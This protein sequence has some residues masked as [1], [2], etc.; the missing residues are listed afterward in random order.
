MDP[1]TNPP[2]W[3]NWEEEFIST[4]DKKEKK[5]AYIY[6][7]KDLQV[8][9]KEFE[10]ASVY[11]SKPFNIDGNVAEISLE[12]DEYNP[13]KN[14]LNRAVNHFDTSVE[15]YICFKDVVTS[16]DDWIPILPKQKQII[17]N[18]FLL[19]EDSQT[20]KLRFKY[21]K[22]KETTVYKNGVKL[23]KQFWS[24]APDNTIKIDKN[25]DKYSIYTVRYSPDINTF[26]PWDIELNEEDRVVVPFVDVNGNREEIFYEGANRNGEIVLSKHPYV[27]Y[28]K[29]NADDLTYRPIKI[30]LQSKDA[31][32]KIAAPNNTTLDIVGP[33][34]IGASQVITKNITDYKYLTESALT[35]YNTTMVNGQPVNAQFEYYQDGRKLCFTE[36]FNNSNIISNQT[37]NHG[38]AVVRVK[39]DYLKVKVRFKIIVRN[40]SNKSNTITPSVRGYSL[41]FKVAR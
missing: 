22:D 33:D 14:S 30:T 39:Y 3:L 24:Y 31:I 11:V 37:T 20:C 13:T 15:Y 26:S 19:F 1:K 38:D 5:Y 34:P 21:D 6:G 29:I 36:T 23:D 35:P 17:E 28:S 25:F 40:T 12:A 4:Y 16:P 41:I 8:K 2:E 18:E 7:V 9:Y 32:H 27:D 10:T